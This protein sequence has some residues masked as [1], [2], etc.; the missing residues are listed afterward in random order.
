MKKTSLEPL[1][2]T[3]LMRVRGVGV[4]GGE[5]EG[6]V[7]GEGGRG[8]AGGGGV[9]TGELQVTQY[10]HKLFHHGSSHKKLK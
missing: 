1:A 10:G 7:G 5:G 6:G 9:S 3:W 4:R 8:G 2:G